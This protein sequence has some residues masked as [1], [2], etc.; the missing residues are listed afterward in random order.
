MSGREVA[1]ANALRRQQHE[2]QYGR[3]PNNT[4]Y[5]MDMLS[6]EQAQRDTAHWGKDKGG[7]MG[8]LAR[9]Q[10]KIPNPGDL[11]NIF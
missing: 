6:G 8:T 5:V 2:D 3:D 10:E 9:G 4:Q 11:L 1:M 7:L